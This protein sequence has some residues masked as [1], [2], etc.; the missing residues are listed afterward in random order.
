MGTNDLWSP[1]PSAPH[2]HVF[3]G[4]GG[5]TA[6]SSIF[7]LPASAQ[8]EDAAESL[9]AASN[10]TDP[11]PEEKEEDSGLSDLAIGLIAGGSA[12]VV[13]GAGYMI[14]REKDG[15]SRMDSIRGANILCSAQE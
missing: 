1:R 5:K 11:A 10:T 14:W 15:Y 9:D 8:I 2:H 7:I 4:A 3:L 13:L 12:L 6:K